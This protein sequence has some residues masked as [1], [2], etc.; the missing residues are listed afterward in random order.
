MQFIKYLKLRQERHVYI[1][2]LTELER[3]MITASTINIPP[4]T[5]L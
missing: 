2:L 5:G 1:S 3:T 4:L